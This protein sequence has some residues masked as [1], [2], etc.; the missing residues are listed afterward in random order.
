ARFFRGDRAGL[1]EEMQAFRR[2]HG[3]IEGQLAGRAGVLADLLEQILRKPGEP[4]AATEESGWTTFA[5]NP[6]RNACFQKGPDPQMLAPGPRRRIPLDGGGLPPSP[7]SGR[8][9]AF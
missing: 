3:R 7:A 4:L 6:E 5:G 9:F 2:R 1:V 8:S